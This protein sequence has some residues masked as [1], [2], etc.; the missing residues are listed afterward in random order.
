LNH[1]DPFGLDVWIIRRWIG[2]WPHY[3]VLG[4]NY[5]GTYW[6]AD[7][8]PM[9]GGLRLPFALWGPFPLNTRGDPRF[10]GPSAL[11]PHSLGE[12][13]KVVRHVEC[14]EAATRKAKELARETADP[15]NPAPRWDLVGHNCWNYAA[16]IADRAA[17]ANLGDFLRRR[18]RW[19]P[20][21]PPNR[22]PDS[23]QKEAHG[24]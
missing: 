4:D 8:F 9:R 6:Y 23:E 18:L 1:L 11:D 14:G 16:R 7:F 10:I 19:A 22:S 3:F 12:G 5:D 21:A 13:E 24:E 15:A 17:A 20:V 2:L